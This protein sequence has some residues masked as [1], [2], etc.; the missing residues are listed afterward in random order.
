MKVHVFRYSLCA[1]A[2]LLYL[3]IAASPINPQTVI[4]SSRIGGYSEDITFVTAGPLKDKI[5]ILD[6]FDIFAVENKKK[7]T[8]AMVKLF[9]VKVP[10]IDV[11][12]NGIAYV[13]S[14]DLFVLNQNVHTNK[15]YFFD[16]AG[17]YKGRRDIQYLNPAY[18]PEHLEGLAYIPASSPFFPDHLVM[19]VVDNLLGGPRRLEIMR[20]DGVVE[21][22]LYRPDWPTN[23]T[24][25]GMA[26]VSFLA[27]NRLLVTTYDNNI[28]TMDFNGNIVSGPV[29][30]PE[31]VG[32]EGII[33]MSDSSIAV[34]E[35]PQEL[36]FL[37]KNLSRLPASDRNDLI[38]LNVNQP[39]GIAW[40]PD[41]NQFLIKHVSEDFSGLGG[42]VASAPTSLDSAT[43]VVN[44][45][46]LNFLRRLK[47]L[48]DEHLIATLQNGGPGGRAIL[49]YNSD[50]TFNSQ[51]S[52][53][54]VSLGFN[55]GA[56]V[57]FTYLPTTHEFV[58]NF[59]G[60]GPSPALERRSLRV[61][62]RTGTLVRTIDL[63]S[64]GTTSVAGLDFFNSPDGDRFI[65]L[66]SAGRGFITDLNGDPRDSNGVPF[67]EFNS[68][69]KLGLL[70]RVDVAA[71]TTGPLAGAF[72]MV[73]SQN[74][75]VVI[76]TLD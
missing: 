9:N 59:N 75:E 5:V 33:Q 58:V 13:A 15:L 16:Q 50:G 66:G 20:R 26:G 41:T 35:Y 8:G 46:S 19:V 10:E 34:V 60:A 56:P 30:V 28:W 76:F 74:G 68:R 70:N 55:P 67:G 73:D 64:T 11:F 31:G 57:S 49:L 44:V 51:V 42:R 62:S 7:P 54:P 39:S 23:F 1:A 25:A 14:E 48:P 3:A 47:Y 71:I 65:I 22:E 40:N 32:F 45:V 52:L 12:P 21:A 63:T 4:S 43:P 53:A 18:L 36:L 61:L 6:G 72:A 17:A 69:V 29:T 27:P 2:T 24:E 37:D 38:G